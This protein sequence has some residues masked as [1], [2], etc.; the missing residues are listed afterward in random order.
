MF[1]A[2]FALLAV[3][4]GATPAQASTGDILPPFN[5]GETW[6]I[7]Q[8]YNNPSVSHTGSSTYG[9]DL[10]GAG[11]DNSAS[12]RTVRAPMDGT[13]AYYEGPFGNLCINV[14]G[15]RSITLT[16]INSSITGGTVSAGQAIGTVAAPYDRRNNGVSHIHFQMWA[17]PGCYSGTGIPFDSAHGAR[18]CGAPDLTASGPNGGNGTWSGTSFTGVLCGATQIN[19]LTSQVTSGGVQHVYFGTLAGKVHETWWVPGSN[20]PS[21]GTLETTGGS[22]VTAMSSQVTGGNTQHVYWGTSSGKVYETWWNSSSSVDTE[23]LFDTGGSEITALSSQVTP[24]GYQHVYFGTASGKVYEVWWGNGSTLTSVLLS[25]TGG[26]SV[27]AMSSQLTN[28]N[29]QHVYWGTSSGIVYETWWSPTSAAPS[30][31]QLTTISGTSIT[32]MS[33]QITGSNIQHVYFGT[34]SGKVYEVWWGGGNPVSR[35]LID[36]TAGPRVTAISS[37]VTGSIQ[38]VYWGTSF[39]KVYES[40][41]GGGNPVSTTQLYDDV[42]EI[43]AMSSSITGT[44]TNHVYFGSSTGLVYETWWVPGSSSPSTGQL[45]PN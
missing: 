41:F 18:I 16:H 21:T 39:G 1:I 34:A 32:A 27:T 36:Q 11:C 26:S 17:S 38:H 23:L 19:T 13:V 25:Q 40:W 15:G 44:N 14:S 22:S 28:G 24:S 6:N 5:P 33:S 29:T 45:H 8:G 3:L 4:F 2:V 7:C 20:P 9:L 30:T 37:Q 10:T 42:G 35:S 12:G 43:T 31:G